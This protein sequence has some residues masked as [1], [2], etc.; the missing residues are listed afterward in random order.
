MK[1]FERWTNVETWRVNL[2]MRFTEN[3]EDFA[4]LELDEIMDALINHAYKVVVSE[5]SIATDLSEAFLSEVDWRNIAYAILDM[6]DVKQRVDNYEER[7]INMGD[8]DP[9]IWTNIPTWRANLEMRFT[10]NLEDFAGL[11]LYEIIIALI[12][13]ATKKVE[14]ENPL[15]TDLAADFL[16][17]V[18]WHNLAQVILDDLHKLGYH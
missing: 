14:S 8:F 17:E 2:E 5:N 12:N 18:D 9:R 15:A 3:L 10:E 13:H 11:E 6:L 7:N 4:G 1:K 16:F